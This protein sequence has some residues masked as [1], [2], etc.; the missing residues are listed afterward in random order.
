MFPHDSRIIVRVVGFLLSG[1]GSGSDDESS[2]SIF[3]S[4]SC[5]FL[6]IALRSLTALIIFWEW[7]VLEIDDGWL[8]KH[9]FWIVYGVR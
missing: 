5:Y 2:C 9:S 7:K 6:S 4:L 3:I 8:D 1:I